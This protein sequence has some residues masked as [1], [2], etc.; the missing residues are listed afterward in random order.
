M[1]ENPDR[2]QRRRSN[3]CI[4]FDPIDNGPTDISS[5]YDPKDALTRRSSIGVQNAY[6]QVIRSGPYAPDSLL[7]EQEMV[8]DLE[9]DTT[10]LLS[11]SVSTWQSVPISGSS[12]STY[13]SPPVTGYAWASGSKSDGGA[14]QKSTSI[15]SAYHAAVYKPPPLPP[16]SLAK[17]TITGAPSPYADE[18]SPPQTPSAM[19][20][21]ASDNSNNL[22]VKEA[23]C[24][25]RHAGEGPGN[26]GSSHASG[27]DNDGDEPSVLSLDASND[28]L[29]VDRYTKNAND[30]LVDDRA[31]VGS[32]FSSLVIAPEPVSMESTVIPP[33]L[34]DPPFA[35]E[36]FIM[37]V[38]VARITP[39][40][41][42]R[43]GS[44]P[45]SPLTP[46]MTSSP[47]TDS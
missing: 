45:S 29:T 17:I 7:T 46:S 18:A 33:P 22:P 30:G 8:F 31:S 10:Q 23:S 14:L 27:D 39:T 11:P 25:T 6:A 28:T 42:A 40:A 24:P 32:F 47:T 15:T 1:S 43:V 3:V 2:G 9:A 34:P 5:S 26:G 44:P 41:S 38:P 16:I 36:E 20:P 35:S 37:P 13:R 21:G 4:G 19:S 12:F